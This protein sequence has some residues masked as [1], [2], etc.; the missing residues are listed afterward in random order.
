MKGTSHCYC[1]KLFNSNQ[2]LLGKIISNKLAV[3]STMDTLL[4]SQIF[5][6]IFEIENYKYAA[7]RKKLLISTFV[8]R[9]KITTLGKCY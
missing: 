3:S 2:Q 7:L 4:K 8:E 6:D 5:V 1:S 9:F